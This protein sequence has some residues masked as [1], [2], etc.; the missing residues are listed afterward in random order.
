M[1]LRQ[2]SLVGPQGKP[3]LVFSV[4][5]RG[6]DPGKFGGGDPWAAGGR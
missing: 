3:A 2:K 4:Q 5:R 6:G 1:F